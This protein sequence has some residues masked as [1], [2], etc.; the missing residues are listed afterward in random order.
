MFPPR[1]ANFFELGRQ[2]ILLKML[3]RAV[4]FHYKL[5][6]TQNNRL[7]RVMLHELICY[8]NLEGSSIKTK[9][10]LANYTSL[11]NHFGLSFEE[12]QSIF[13]TKNLVA[14]DIFFTKG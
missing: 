2:H 13:R 10:W 9:S 1:A 4:K 12:M 8:S 5:Y 7:P 6:T 3:A 14:L 11:L